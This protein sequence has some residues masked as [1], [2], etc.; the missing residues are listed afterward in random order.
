MADLRHAILLIEDNHD[1]RD[2]LQTLLTVHGFDVICAGDGEEALALVRRFQPC[3]ILLDLMMPR[4]SGWQFREEQLREP[5]LARIP[6]ILLSGA[7]ALADKAKDLRVDDYFEKPIDV[8]A[9]LTR[10]EGYCGPASERGA[11]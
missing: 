11:R 1:A 2:A 5:E 10:L 9:L 6:V 4:K 3:V 7:G 8:E